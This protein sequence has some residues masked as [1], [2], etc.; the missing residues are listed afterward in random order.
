M[1]ICCMYL[2]RVFLLLLLANLLSCYQEIN[3]SKDVLKFNISQGLSSLDPAFAK[4]LSTTW[5]VGNIFDCLFTLDKNTVLTPQLASHYEVNA[6]ATCYTIYMTRGVYFHKN[7]CFASPDST[8]MA[9]AFDAVYSLQRLL[10]PKTASPGSWILNGKVD[11]VQPFK[12]LDSFT[13]QIRLQKPFAQFI[14]NLTM[15][16]TSVIPREAVSYYGSTFRKNPVGTG[17]YRMKVWEE[18]T[19]LFLEKNPNYFQKDTLGVQLPYISHVKVTFNEQK[20]MEFLMLKK[21]ELHFLK[22]VDGSI[23][24]DV[25]DEY[26]NL[27]SALKKDFYVQKR[28]YLNTEY[29]AIIHSNPASPLSHKKVRQA[30]NLAINRQE[31]V[32][33][34][35][36]NL[37]NPA[38]KGFVA[39]GMPF[40]DTAFEG[41]SFNPTKAKELLAQAGFSNSKKAKIQLHINNANVDLA[42]FVI[43]QLQQV[44]FEVDLKMHPAE[45]M[46]Q[47]AKEGKIDFFRRS[48][49]ADY[50]DAESNFACF[51]SQNGAPPNYT[52]FKN[53]QYDLLYESILKEPSAEK[54]IPIYKKMEQLLL[55]EAP[56]VPI[57]YDQSIR[58]I[59]KNVKN[60]EQNSIN[61]LDLRTVKIE[62]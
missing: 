47:L 5:M 55:E 49:T 36:N 53:K 57:F 39:L 52:R 12:I 26:G 32:S 54:R 4:D 22:D 59:H 9:T 3:K 6:D 41:Y 50:P 34:L 48:W 13:F 27:L 30:L 1:Y 2:K 31:I 35:K 21:G 24:H 15:Q 7:A 18:G 33:S 37:V 58:L 40:Y 25:F 28:T 17:P 38:N 19:A 23:V 44:G 60:L 11:S 46:M 8:R 62:K 61:H 29:L 16:Y 45:T 14:Y 51:Y 10:D 20:K 56:I 42:E 43:Y